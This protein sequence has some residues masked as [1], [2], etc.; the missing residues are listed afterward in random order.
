MPMRRDALRQNTKNT[1]DYN[2]DRQR[3][4]RSIYCENKRQAEEMGK[5]FCNANA[6]YIGAI[7]QCSIVIAILF[8]THTNII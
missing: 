2:Q 8:I 7:H 6:W 1:K 4:K 3:G 5:G